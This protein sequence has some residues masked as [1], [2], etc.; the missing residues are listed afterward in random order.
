LITAAGG[1]TGADGDFPE[2][3]MAD[4]EPDTDASTDAIALLR[5]QHLE[6]EDLFARLERLQP[7]AQ[8][9]DEAYLHERRQL[10]DLVV[11][12]LM[13]H[14][15]IEEDR[16]Y[17]V[18]REEVPDGGELVDRAVEQ[19]TRAEAALAKIDGLSPDNVDFDAHLRELIDGV[20][21][22]V[23]MEETEI[24]PRVESAL[25]GSRLR[26]LGAQLEKAMK[27]APT[28]PHPHTPPATSGVGKL[29]AR[30]AA[31]LDRMRDAAGGRERG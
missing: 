29:L 30:G 1:Y 22:H 6:V 12:K 4:H 21:A 28:R 17:P 7:I 13:K 3:T 14:A 5:S 9:S 20:R 27:L 11:N 25:G 31:V 24:F 16:F 8:S 19:H 26:E 15:G 23:Q 2:A 10:T 18:V